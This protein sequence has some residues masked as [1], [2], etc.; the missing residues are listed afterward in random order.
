MPADVPD[1]LHMNCYFTGRT[2]SIVGDNVKDA[3][4][5][6]GGGQLPKFRAREF[7]REYVERWEKQDRKRR[8][9]A[10]PLSPIRLVIDLID[11]IIYAWRH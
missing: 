6:Q 10:H 1:N 5:R 3:D 9:L 4:R 2:R 8:R 11:N 7:D